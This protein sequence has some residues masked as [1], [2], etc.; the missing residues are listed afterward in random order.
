MTRA[1]A[2]DLDRRIEV[3]TAAPVTDQAGDVGEPVWT[4]AFK[5]WAACLPSQNSAS[6]SQGAQL[7]VRQSDTVWRIRDDSE[8]RMIAPESHRVIHKGRIFEI[9]G[10]RRIARSKRYA[11]P[12]VHIAAGSPR[13]SGAGGRKWLRHR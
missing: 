3:Q 7:V 5:R 10:S 8:A 2:G 13:R 11:G 9:V 4:L 1:A 12:G 6:E